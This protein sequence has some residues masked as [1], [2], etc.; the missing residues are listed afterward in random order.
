MRASSLKW[1]ITVGLLGSTTCPAHSSAKT[2]PDQRLVG[3]WLMI[4]DRVDFPNGCF[5][6]L[7]IQ[8]HPDG[9]I[10]P[11]ARAGTWRLSG[12]RL[13]ETA[14]SSDPLLVD[15]S[16]VERGKPHESSLRWSG[17]E[18]FSNRGPDGRA[19]RFRRCPGPK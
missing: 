10:R 17:L 4:A 18:R 13:M 19:R 8:Y 9:T 16:A 12:E 5:S 1:L 3:A 11:G 14:T 7:P 15:D 2:G 6:D